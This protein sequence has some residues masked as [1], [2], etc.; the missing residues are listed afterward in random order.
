MCCIQSSHL[1]Y[2]YQLVMNQQIELV[3]P[4]VDKLVAV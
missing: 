2:L 4:K 1:S 3:L